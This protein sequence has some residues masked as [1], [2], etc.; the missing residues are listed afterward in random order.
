LGRGV[1]WV[2][3]PEWLVKF[4][5]RSL[6]DGYHRERMRTDLD[7]L[8]IPAGLQAVGTRDAPFEAVA[9]VN[10]LPLGAMLRVTRGDLDVLLA[11]TPLGLCA[12]DDRCPH[13][14][15]PLSIGTLDDCVVGCPLHKGRFDLSTGAVVQFPTTGG[16]D[17]D[18]GYHPV[19]NPVG[20]EA[21]PEPTDLKARARALTRIRRLRY[22]PLRVNGEQ[23]EI[24]FPR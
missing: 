1:V 15:A 3:F 19:W 13:M 23:I 9:S 2:E 10:E 4:P 5:E 24:C 8:P 22:Y 17:A 21:K 20:A 16:V 14:A 12:T 11:H 6:T 18:G 7:V